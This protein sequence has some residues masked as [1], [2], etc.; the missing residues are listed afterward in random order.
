MSTV[1]GWLHVCDECPWAGPWHEH[2]YVCP[3]CG[4]A[5]EHRVIRSGP[6]LLQFG[7]T[8]REDAGIEH[9]PDPECWWKT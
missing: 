7:L 2:V 1:V 9:P 6:G 3:K 4:D 8:P 5:T